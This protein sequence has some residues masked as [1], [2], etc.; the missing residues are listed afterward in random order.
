MHEVNKHGAA[1][2][3]EVTD[4]TSTIPTATVNVKYV[5]GSAY[6]G[7][8]H[9]VVNCMPCRGDIAAIRMACPLK[10]GKEWITLPDIQ[11]SWPVGSLLC[12]DY[13]DLDSKCSH[14]ATQESECII[15]MNGL[16]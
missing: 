2:N 16:H 9:V 6:T 11:A 12:L 5:F 3:A 4:C 14:L 7:L 15:H 13:I 1:W 10:G 8:D